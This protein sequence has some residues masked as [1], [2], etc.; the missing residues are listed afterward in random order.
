MALY[1]YVIIVKPCFV[2]M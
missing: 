2:A 1:H